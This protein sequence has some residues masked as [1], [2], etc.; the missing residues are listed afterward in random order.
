M[1]GALW[2]IGKSAI[3]IEQMFNNPNSS[4][5]ICQENNTKENGMKGARMQTKSIW[6]FLTNAPKGKV[7]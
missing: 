7:V 6:L 3:V 5:S 1:V 2:F 4:L